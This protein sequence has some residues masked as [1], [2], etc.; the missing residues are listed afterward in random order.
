[1]RV[2]CGE[3]ELIPVIWERIEKL[4]NWYAKRFYNLLSAPQ[5]DLEDLTQ[6]GYIALVKAVNHY[7]PNADAKFSSYL[8][9]WLRQAFDDT[10]G[11]RRPRDAM[12]HLGK[13]LDDPLSDESET[14]VADLIEDP[15][16]TAA[17]DEAERRIFNEQLHEA[18]EG[19]L[20]MLDADEA[21]VMRR[22]YYDG[23][24]PEEIGVRQ[25][26]LNLEHRAMRKCRSP[27]AM[28]SLRQF[29][30][31]A[32]PSRIHGLRPTETAVILREDIRSGYH[33]EWL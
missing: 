17:F 22:R 28:K 16:A 29:L 26:I 18:L 31:D 8:L 24:R 13:S 33:P 1:M 6:S 25:E 7:N 19:V 5:C 21:S 4:V 14:V 9:F 27:A 2:Q 3:T 32:T 12:M 10:A 30:D 20:Q 11:L 23:L 15:T